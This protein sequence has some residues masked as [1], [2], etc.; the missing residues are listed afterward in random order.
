MLNLTIE[1]ASVFG[2]RPSYQLSEESKV[3][4]IISDNL[5]L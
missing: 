5:K 1:A 4:G 2:I 3:T